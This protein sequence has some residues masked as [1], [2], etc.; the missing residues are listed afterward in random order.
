VCLLAGDYNKVWVETGKA[1]AGCPKETIDA[2]L[3]GTAT[4]LYRV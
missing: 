2:I 3:G 4:K 1:L